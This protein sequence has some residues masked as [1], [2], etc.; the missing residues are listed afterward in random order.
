VCIRDRGYVSTEPLPINDRGVFT[1]LLPSNDKGKENRLKT[2][3]NRGSQD[4]IWVVAT[5]MQKRRGMGRK[6]L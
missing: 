2:A 4:F 6:Q 1:E 5:L 3:T